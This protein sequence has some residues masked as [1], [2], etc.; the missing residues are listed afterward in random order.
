MMANPGEIF[1]QVPSDSSYLELIRT[2]IVQL[3]TKVGFSVE[4]TDQ[5]ELAVDEACTN[6]VK[7]AYRD[8]ITGLSKIDLLITIDNQKTT[9]VVRD[10]GQGF[11]V[12]NV[13]EPD[14]EKY[15]AEFRSGGLGIYLMKSLMDEVSYEIQPGIKTEVRM[16]K[17]FGND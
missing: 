9:I 5:I 13:P 4:D 12:A 14:M 15:L 8:E 7:Y 2:F 10:H 16:T 11:D 6:V 1:I 17:Y 3:M